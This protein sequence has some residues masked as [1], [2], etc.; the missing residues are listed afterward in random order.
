M[1]TTFLTYSDL[2]TSSFSV[3]FSPYWDHIP[4]F[5]FGMLRHEIIKHGDS[6]SLSKVSS[7]PKQD[8]FYLCY[9]LSL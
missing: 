4:L 8:L 2:L 6:Q 9:P 5:L 7:G 1:M 3:D